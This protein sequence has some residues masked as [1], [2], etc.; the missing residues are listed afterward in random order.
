VSIELLLEVGLGIFDAHQCAQRSLECLTANRTDSDRWS[1]SE[2]LNYPKSALCHAQ[3][4]PQGESLDYPLGF[5]TAPLSI[6]ES[7]RTI[8]PAISLI[9]FRPNLY[10]TAFGCEFTDQVNEIIGYLPVT[11]I[12]LS[13]AIK[14]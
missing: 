10:G 13:F 3:S 5:R 1:A 4:L 8:W 12:L 9:A 14:E 6:A 11:V 7:V 2:I